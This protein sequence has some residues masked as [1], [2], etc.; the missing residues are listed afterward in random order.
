MQSILQCTTGGGIPQCRGGGGG[1]RDVGGGR[2]PRCRGGSSNRGGSP[3]ALQMYVSFIFG[4]M[5]SSVAAKAGGRI[6]KRHPSRM[7]LSVSVS[8][9]RTFFLMYILKLSNRPVDQCT[10]HEP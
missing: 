1:S 10:H 2:I 8:K 7:G 4:Y 5:H 9:I 3:N 6:Q